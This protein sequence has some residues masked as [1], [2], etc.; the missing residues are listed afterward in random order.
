MRNK[1]FI[2]IL[3]TV[4][5]L[6]LVGCGS[7]GKLVEKLELGATY[8]EQGDYEN[9]IV[10][11][12]EAI[13]MDKYA[14]DAY[15][16]VLDAKQKNGADIAEIEAFAGE[17][18]LAMNE[19]YSAQIEDTEEWEIVH[20]LLLDID[21]NLDYDSDVRID[22]YLTMA[23]VLGKDAWNVA[24]TTALRTEA[25]RLEDGRNY[26][27]AL[28]IVEVMEAMDPEDPYVPSMKER[29]ESQIALLRQYED[30]F[31]PLA[32][33]IEAKD[34]QT[35]AKMAADPRIG[36]VP[37]PYYFIAEE[38]KGMR[39]FIGRDDSRD[40]C[41]FY[42]VEG[43]DSE[44]NGLTGT[45]GV[46]EY[47]TPY[48]SYYEGGFEGE[49]AHGNGHIAI[50]SG[51]TTLVDKDVNVVEGRI[52]CSDGE[53]YDH[54]VEKAEMVVLHG[55]SASVINTQEENFSDAYMGLLYNWI[56]VS[57]GNVEHLNEDDVQFL[58]WDLIYLGGEPHT[59]HFYGYDRPANATGNTNGAT[60][61][62]TGEVGDTS[63]AT[64]SLEANYDE[65]TGTISINGG[66]TFGD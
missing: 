49:Y 47:G 6:G 9:A 38:Y 28:K 66:F 12:E 10:A 17:V 27:E 41:R 22:I 40:G 39:I 30:L 58:A 48:V 34:W 43:G 36:E 42:L 25:S 46:S 14:W 19:K 18:L 11:Y 33:S 23:E 15:A 65:E 55:P 29:L 32:K 57:L 26:T 35:V 20:T 37:Q 63:N 31:V 50:Q 8:L 44:C 51:E 13:Q 52:Q 24:Y 5:T 2:T 45:I 7:S 1:C 54:Y 4:L 62:T 61:G 60:T 53:R 3:V 16:G 59:L 21:E 64:G 56:D